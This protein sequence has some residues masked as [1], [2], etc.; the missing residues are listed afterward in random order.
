MPADQDVE[1]HSVDAVVDA[2]VGDRADDIGA[3]TES[4]D[5]A[6]ALFVS[7][8]VPREVVVH[9]CCESVLQV[10]SLGE[11]VGGD[12]QPGSVV[13]GELGDPRL[14]LFR[15]QVAGD[16]FDSQ[17][18]VFFRQCRAEVFGQVFGSGG[19]IGRRRSGDSPRRGVPSEA[20]SGV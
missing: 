5:A 3:L 15:R 10:H 20:R 7:G 11:A 13:S 17:G 16:R 9:H 4:V 12:Q 6:F 19:C 14:P 1:Y 8:G 2:V 18:A